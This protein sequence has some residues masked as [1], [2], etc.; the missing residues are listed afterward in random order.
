[1]KVSIGK[2]TQQGQED[3]FLDRACPSDDYYARSGEPAGIW[4]GTAAEHLGV[5]GERVERDAL[6]ALLD[7]DDPLTGERLSLR[8]TKP[9]AYT[10]PDGTTKIAH[11]LRGVDLTF[12]APKEF[13][14]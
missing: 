4:W 12:S 6:T 1:M 8:Q 3:Y 7:G 9:R 2:L 5:A 14:T 13:S 11:P 10:Q